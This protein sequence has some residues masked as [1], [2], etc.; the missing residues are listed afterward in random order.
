M[1]RSNPSKI[2]A[3]ILD[4][5]EVLCY[6]PTAEEMGRMAAPFGMAPV[7]F[8][9]LW[10]WDRLRYDRGDVSPDEYWSALAKSAGVQLTPEQ[11]GELCQWD[12]EMW[13]HDNPTMVQWLRHVHSSGMKTA[14]LSNMPHDMIRHVRQKFAWLDQ[15]DHQTF[16]AEVNLVKPD[17]AIY[18]H[19]LRG[20][21]VAASEALFVDDKE[22][23]VQGAQAVGIRAIQFRSV[24]QFADDL[25]KLGFSILPNASRSNS[26]VSP[27]SR[28]V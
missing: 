14:L 13:S 28:L 15:F 1:D 11:F 24:E 16:S 7:P 25:K 6:A 20:V 2:K 12:L 21:G 5:G 4:Y 3:V 26:T 27:V 10:D 17:R 23:N 19:S 9:Q 8:R 18:E 22:R